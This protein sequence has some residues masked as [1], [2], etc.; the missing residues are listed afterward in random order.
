MS[1]QDWRELYRSVVRLSR[2]VARVGRRPRYSDALIVAMFVWGVWHDRPQVWTCRRE[3]YG[4]CFRPRRMPSLSQ[5]NRRIRTPRCDA[6]QRLVLEYWARKRPPTQLAYLDSRPLRVGECSKDQAARAGRV[7]GGFARGYRMHAIFGGNGA[8]IVSETAPMNV[9]ESRVARR[10][11]RR[12]PR[13]YVVLA[14]ANYDRTPLYEAAARRGVIL[15]AKPKKNAGQGHHPQSPVRLRSLEIWRACPRAMAA[16]R[17]EIERI[18]SRLS[19]FGGG[20]A[21]LPAWVR[22]PPRVRRWVTAKLI[23]YHVRLARKT[24]AA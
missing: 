12:L 20:L 2:K 10:L 14:D 19:S 11:L 3:N 13:G 6:L 9:G 15:L 24:A 22:T 4:P 5:F 21:P 7:Y 18:F 16:Q 17:T 8:V 1:S 23:I